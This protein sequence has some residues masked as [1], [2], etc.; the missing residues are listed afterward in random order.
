[1]RSLWK[2]VSPNIARNA[3]I[4]AAELASYDQVGDWCA[5]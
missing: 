4:N 5:V 2:G 3:L 1:M